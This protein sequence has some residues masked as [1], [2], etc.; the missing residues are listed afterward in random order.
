MHQVFVSIG[1]NIDPKENIE[2]AKELLSELF[3]C[4]FSSH[5]ET[6]SEGFKGNDFINCVVRFETSLLPS[7]LRN[8]LKQIEFRVGRTE[9]QKGMSNRVID[10]DLILYGDEVIKEGNFDIPSND[11]EEYLFVLE[12]L[13]EIA[14][15]LLHPVSNIPFSE[16]LKKLKTN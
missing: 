13:V 16:L 8:N 2:I 6:I 15:E 12:P 5:Y 14:G 1:S 3:D 10:L 7:E 9:N 11:I 4:T